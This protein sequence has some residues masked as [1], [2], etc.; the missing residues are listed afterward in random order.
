MMAD[1]C[2]GIL[3]RQ[4]F[5]PTARTFI[6]AMPTEGR[7]ACNRVFFASPESIEDLG[8]YVP[9]RYLDGGLV[10]LVFVR[11]DRYCFF[12]MTRPAA[13]APELAPTLLG[14]AGAYFEGAP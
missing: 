5:E 1:Y 9:P 6:E 12:P 14:R 11:G 7:A 13:E 4:G 2:D 3:W 8:H 10:Y